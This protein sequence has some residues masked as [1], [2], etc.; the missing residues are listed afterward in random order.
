MKYT[1]IISTKSVELSVT[2]GVLHRSMSN[3][4]LKCRIICPKD[5]GF[6]DFTM[7]ITHINTAQSNITLRRAT[8]TG[9][10]KEGYFGCNKVVKSISQSA[11][12][13]DLA[14]TAK[15]NNLPI[16]TI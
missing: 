5:S 9:R 3:T 13:S 10:K 14:M 7:F 4:I 8:A 12:K 1:G 11:R 15:G 6:V 2:D 16:K